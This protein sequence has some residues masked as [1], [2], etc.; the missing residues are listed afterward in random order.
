MP[1][2]ALRPDLPGIISLFDYHPEAARPLCDLAE[3]MLRGPSPLDP[4]VRELIAAY[5]SSLNGCRFCA[6]SHRTIAARLLGSVARVEELLAAPTSTAR[7][8]PKLAALLRVAAAVQGGRP[9][10][11]SDTIADARDAGATDREI[12]DTVLIAAMFCMYNRYVDGLGTRVPDDASVYDEIASR[13]TT[14]GYVDRPSVPEA[15]TVEE[16]AVMGAAL[17]L[18]ADRS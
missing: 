4:G 8:G 15:Q 6:T 7:L 1:H 10:S 17:A 13:I 16:E 18:T 9:G 3:V 12:H 5:V 11:T 14:V 2:I